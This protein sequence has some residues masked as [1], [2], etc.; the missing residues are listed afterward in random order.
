MFSPERSHDGYSSHPTT[1]PSDDATDDDTPADGGTGGVLDT[2]D[3]MG[4]VLESVDSTFGPDPMS[5]AAAA[6][7]SSQRDVVDRSPSPLS[8]M[9]ASSLSQVSL[10][11]VAP[12]GKLLVGPHVGF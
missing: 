1:P 7:V 9:S 11:K 10:K 6:A 3:S 5:M 2:L 12:L 8:Q 4:G